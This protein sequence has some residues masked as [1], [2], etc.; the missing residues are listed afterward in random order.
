M[1]LLLSQGSQ[2]LIEESRVTLGNGGQG[3]YHVGTGD[4]QRYQEF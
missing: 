2:G 4:R 1:V 3:S